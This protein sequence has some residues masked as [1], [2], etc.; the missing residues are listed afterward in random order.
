MQI[1]IDPLRHAVRTGAQRTACV[2]GSARFSYQ[3]MMQRCRQ[4]AG[5]MDS[6]GMQLGDR[7]ALLAA[8]S[9]Q[10]L[11]CYMGV[12]SAGQVIVPL[13]TRHAPAELEYALRDSGAR[14]LLTD[15]PPTELGSLTDCVE[16]VLSLSDDYERLLHDSSPR[17]LG[18]GVDENSLAGLFYTG[19]TTGASKGGDADASQS[20][21]QHIPLD[22]GAD[23]SAECGLSGGRPVISCRWLKF[24]I[25]DL[26]DWRHSSCCAY[27][28]PGPSAR[29]D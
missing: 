26:L 9:H 20:N 4:L 13:N 22:D 21:R 19:G 23:T 12:P 29:F 3:Q 6:L 18:A 2:D 28:R 24:R 11:E 8:N 25:V 5:A 1:M 15:R 16:Q 17:A 14:V 7:V 27:F 10:Y